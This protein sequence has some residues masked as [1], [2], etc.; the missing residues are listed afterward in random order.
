MAYLF[1]F[2]K[3]YFAEQK[4]QIL[5]R[6]NLLITCNSC[7]FCV[8]SK[9][10]STPLGLQRF[11]PLFFSL[12]ASHLGLWI[13]LI[14]F[15]LWCKFRSLVIFFTYAYLVVSAQFDE[16]IFIL[17]LITSISLLKVNWPYV[18]EF[19]SWFPVLYKVICVFILFALLSWLLC[20]YS[21]SGNQIVL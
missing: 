18:Y 8:L 3:L 17:H 10:L 21:K 19:C 11:S 20:L 7:G 4:S 13:I 14:N 12:C 15:Y 1:I 6:F 9:S 16:K 2:L 5:M